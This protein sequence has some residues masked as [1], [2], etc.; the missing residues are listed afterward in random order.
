MRG[1]E[2]HSCMKSALHS[3]QWNL[4]Y[5]RNL[6]ITHSL[7]ISKQ[8]DFTVMIWKSIK[9]ALDQRLLVGCLTLHIGLLLI[10]FQH[11]KQ[12]GAIRIFPDGSFEARHHPSLT[13]A[14]KVPSLV[15]SDRI[16]P[17]L[18]L[19]RLVECCSGQMDL[20]KCLLKDIVSGR[21]RSKKFRKEPMEFIFI[22]PNQ[23]GECSSVTLQMQLKK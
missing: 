1:K 11:I 5:I 13:L 10:R 7:K 18:K 15:C 20:Q 3:S 2:C 17:R 8:N 12:R 23:C 6:L 21:C 16:K 14:M 4:K 9:H 19:S 22:T